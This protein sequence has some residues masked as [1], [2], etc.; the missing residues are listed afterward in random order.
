MSL[1][2]AL[3][4]ARFAWAA[5]CT[6]I[7]EG[8]LAKRAEFDSFLVFSLLHTHGAGIVTESPM[9]RVSLP[10]ETARRTIGNA[11]ETRH[12]VKRACHGRSGSESGS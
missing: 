9:T 1:A 3:C 5:G 11:K 6:P 12:R 10:G 8:A 4:Q 2:V 7:A